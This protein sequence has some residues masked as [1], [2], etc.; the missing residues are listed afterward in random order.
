[1]GTGTP[2]KWI[3][4]WVGL[5]LSWAQPNP[6]EIAQRYIAAKAWDSARLAWRRLLLVERDSIRRALVYQQLGY[7]ALQIGDSAEALFLWQRSLTYHPTYRLAWQN[8][9]W[10]RQR[11]RP[12]KSA[13]EP[14]SLYQ[15]EASPPSET[16]PPHLGRYPPSGDNDLSWLPAL[17]L[18]K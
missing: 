8:Y 4:W 11:Y 12:P 15:Y 10:L 14:L 13:S 6:Y 5:G 17:R 1:M 2:L 16:A 3:G 7:I 18:A 9:I